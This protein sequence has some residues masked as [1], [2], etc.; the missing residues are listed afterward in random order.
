[1]K[2]ALRSSSVLGVGKTCPPSPPPSKKTQISPKKSELAL[3]SAKVQAGRVGGTGAADRV[4]AAG[5]CGCPEGSSLVC[6][7]TKVRLSLRLFSK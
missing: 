3:G 1:M 4:E 2:A 7:K 5:C 6:V